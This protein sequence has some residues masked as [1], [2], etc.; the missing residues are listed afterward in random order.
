MTSD[1]F[2]LERPLPDAQLAALGDRLIGFAV[3]YARLERGLRLLVDTDGLKQWSQEHHGG[4][5]PLL[6]A[7]ADLYPLVVFHGDV[8]TGKTATAE[9]TAA[10]LAAAHRG[11]SMLFKLSTRVRGTGKVG[12]MS[13]LI[14]DAFSVITNEAGKTRTAYLI[15]DEADS[16]TASRSQG[17]SHHEDKV[18]VNTLIQK[19]DDLRRY[20]GRI[21]VFLCTNR[22]DALDSAILRR[23]FRQERFDRPSDA[24]R[25][26]LFD[27]DL[28][29]VGLEA[30]VL[31]QLVKL[32][33]STRSRP[34][35]TF[36]DIRTR[37]LPDAVARAF[38]DRALSAADLLS[39]AKDLEPTPVLTDPDIATH[40]R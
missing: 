11:E 38:P 12:E 7:L 23:A 29:G 18:A 28:A 24:E 3:R 35:F 19:I 9:A 21:L 1:L 10:R 2:E 20:G 25:R 13:Q 8:C 5:L 4:P 37:L 14:N 36:S 26:E 15:L 40:G 33:G 17:Q 30:S 22:Y 6:D 16:L 32:T 27:C 31:D 39:A 34:A